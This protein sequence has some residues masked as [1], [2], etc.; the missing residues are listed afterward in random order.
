LVPFQVW[1]LSRESTVLYGLGYRVQ[2]S[3]VY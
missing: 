2:Y 3:T 1:F